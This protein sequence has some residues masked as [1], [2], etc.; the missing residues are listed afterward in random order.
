MLAESMPHSKNNKAPANNSLAIF[1]SRFEASLQ[2]AA[3]P[4]SGMA[5]VSDDVWVLAISVNLSTPEQD[6]KNFPEQINSS[7]LDVI[8]WNAEINNL[9]M[10]V[11]LTTQHQQ[12]F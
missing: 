5:R 10:I 9:N 2:A 8:F 4:V 11:L 3:L 7:K 6:L 1:V 12:Y